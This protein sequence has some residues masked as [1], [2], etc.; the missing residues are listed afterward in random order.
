[1]FKAMTKVT[2]FNLKELDG[3][4][5]HIRVESD[6]SAGV[7]TTVL[8]FISDDGNAYV[9]SIT[10]AEVGENVE[11]GENDKGLYIRERKVVK[12]A[13]VNCS[14]CHGC[15]NPCGRTKRNDFTHMGYGSGWDN[16]KPPKK[17][18]TK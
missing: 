7:E 4:D 12:E 11:V 17:A 1:M 13:V 9:L 8:L 3:V 5:G 10:N 18:P 2:P 14:G 15:K 16:T 6:T